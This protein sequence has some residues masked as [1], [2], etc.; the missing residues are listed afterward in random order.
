MHRKVSALKCPY[1]HSLLEDH[2]I[3]SGIDKENN[4]KCAF[5]IGDQSLATL[6]EIVTFRKHSNWQWTEGEFEAIMGQTIQALDAIHSNR[7]VHRDI[8]PHNI[9]YSGSRG[10]FMLSGFGQAKVFTGKPNETHSVVGVPY[11]SI[12][13]LKYFMKEDN[14]TDFASYDCMAADVYSLG[15]TL[16]TTFFLEPTLPTAII[17]LSLMKYEA[18]YPFLRTIIAMIKTPNMG[19]KAISQN[20]NRITDRK[21]REENLI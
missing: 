16:A 5:M 2:I 7:I 14:Y 6:H 13:E 4:D 11:F 8:R 1:I 17:L 9:F 18:Q 15:V 3:E 20:I 10:V 19:I 12:P 21:L